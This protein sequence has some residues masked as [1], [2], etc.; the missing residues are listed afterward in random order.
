MRVWVDLAN[1]PHVPLFIPIVRALQERGDDVVLS[2]RDH[3][4]TL[5]LARAAWPEVAVVGGESPPG[6]AAKARSILS[7]S[8]ALRRF[9]RRTRPDLAL[10]HGSYA[11]AVA[12]RLARV[13]AVTMMDYEHQPANHLSFRLARRVIVPRSFP[14]ASLRRFGARRHKVERYDGF[15]EELY[16]VDVVS[17]PSLLEAL[18]LDRDRVTAATRPPPDGALYHREANPRFDEILEHVLAQGA[19]V[20]L[21]ARTAIQAE[22][23]RRTGVVVPDEPIDGRTLLATV[24][25]MVGAGGTMTRESALL[26]TPTY[27]VFAGELAAVDEE[28]IRQGRIVDLRAEGLPEIARSPRDRRRSDEARAGHILEVVVET[29]DRA[30]ATVSSGGS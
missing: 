3:A 8:E 20:V 17:D 21:L 22:R 23:Y 28:L 12:A 24:D 15:K 29:V 30:A 10:S 9:A 6:R 27:T 2:A 26:G 11:Q 1:S 13:P 5:P 14:E 16:L 7:R 18:G 19:H 4:Q 25:L